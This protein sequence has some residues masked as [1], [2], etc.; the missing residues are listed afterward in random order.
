[1][2]SFAI[3]PQRLAKAKAER[4]CFEGCGKSRAT[5]SCANSRICNV[6]SIQANLDLGKARKAALTKSS[7]AGVFVR[8]DNDSEQNYVSQAKGAHAPLKV[9][10]YSKY[11]NTVPL[12]AGRAICG[13]AEVKSALHMHPANSDN[14]MRGPE[15]RQAGC[16]ENARHIV[17]RTPNPREIAV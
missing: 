15:M 8:D 14:N 16:V 1:M 9:E 17:P 12:G 10:K 7:L 6:L 5:S 13:D 3:R 2:F 4:S 11:S